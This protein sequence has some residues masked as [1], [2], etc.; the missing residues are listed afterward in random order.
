M[1]LDIFE[2]RS[3]DISFIRLFFILSHQIEI[4]VLRD[5]DMEKDG[6]DFLEG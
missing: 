6:R 4:I 2:Q 5:V 1:S 3:R